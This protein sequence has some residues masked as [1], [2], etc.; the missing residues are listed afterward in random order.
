[1]IRGIAVKQLDRAGGV[2]ILPP[3]MQDFWFVED[4]L[5]VL[6]GDLVEA[7]G[8][9]PHSP[10]PPMAEGSH[11]MTING[12][13]VCRRGDRAVCGHPTTGR[14]WWKIT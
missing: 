3:P 12:I 11:W 8:P 9:T 7:H 14:T 2:Q 13:P 4:N 6:I 1:M 5:V 10:P